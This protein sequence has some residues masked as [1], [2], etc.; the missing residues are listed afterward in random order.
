MS[1]M[2]KNNCFEHMFLWFIM[3]NISLGENQTTFFFEYWEKRHLGI[4]YNL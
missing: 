1:T 4:G 3:H 2:F